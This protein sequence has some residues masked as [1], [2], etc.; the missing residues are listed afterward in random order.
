M[1]V[2]TEQCV[3]C[4]FFLCIEA[5]IA[6]RVVYT[7]DAV[8]K[9]RV[10]FKILAGFGG[11]RNAPFILFRARRAGVS[12]SQTRGPSKHQTKTIPEPSPGPVRVLL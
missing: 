4:D 9:S 1:D 10:G 8:L 6:F 11:G 3:E 5:T 12:W 2:T 7:L